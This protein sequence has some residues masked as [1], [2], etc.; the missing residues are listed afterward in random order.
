[1]R[2]FTSHS[3]FVGFAY[4]V[5]EY[6]HLTGELAHR[7][8]A[9]AWFSTPHEIT[10]L[11]FGILCLFAVSHVLPCVARF[12]IALLNLI[13][14]IHRAVVS[15]WL[16]TLDRIERALLGAAKQALKNALAWI[17]ARTKG[18]DADAATLQETRSS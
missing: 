4:F 18:H 15:F 8:P 9:V 13:L 11:A 3:V 12:G 5:A 7:V 6:T 14:V 10:S 2:H 17:E 1:M 16:E